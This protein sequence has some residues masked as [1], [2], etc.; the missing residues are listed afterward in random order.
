MQLFRHEVGVASLARLLDY[1][2][3]LTSEMRDMLLQ[4]QEMNLSNVNATGLTLQ[5]WIDI[6][7]DKASQS[8]GCSLLYPEDPRALTDS[9]YWP[10]FAEGNCLTICNNSGYLLDK[11]SHASRTTVNNLA[12]CGLW[13]TLATRRNYYSDRIANWN[14]TPEFIGS[15]SAKR[16]ALNVQMLDNDIGRLSHW[17]LDWQNLQ[18]VV[19]SRNA[20]VKELGFAFSSSKVGTYEDTIAFPYSCTGDGLFPP[21]EDD[22]VEL[23]RAP[24][25]QN[26]ELQSCIRQICAPRTVNPELG[27]IGVRVNSHY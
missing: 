16:F 1:L 10:Y 18:Y 20:I 23:D 19:A 22:G 3:I 5:D 17:S 13:T 9:E 4:Y 2:E 11:E 12:T 21:L 25:Q 26:F 7:V 24:V 14:S 15:D 27:G 6:N 8:P